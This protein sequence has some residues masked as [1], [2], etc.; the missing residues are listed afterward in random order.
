MTEMMQRIAGILEAVSGFARQTNLL[1]LNAAIEAARARESGI[2]FALV[3]QE[4]RKLAVGASD[5]IGEID[6]LLVD[7]RAKAASLAV[8]Q[9]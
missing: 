2:G 6:Q 3:A 7:G 4:I 1:S 9:T 8:D 5:A